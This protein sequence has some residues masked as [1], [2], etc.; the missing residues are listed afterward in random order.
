MIFNQVGAAPEFLPLKS[1]ILGTQPLD[2]TLLRGQSGSPQSTTSMVDPWHSSPPFDGMGL[3]QM[4]EISLVPGPQLTEQ[5]DA[6]VHALHPPGTNSENRNY[7]QV[8][9]IELVWTNQA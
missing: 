3:E 7:K 4:R 2:L 1:R 9:Q 8:H 5:L 6:S